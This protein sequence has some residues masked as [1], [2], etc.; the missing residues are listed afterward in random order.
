M[1]TYTVLPQDDLNLEVT[2]TDPALAPELVDDSDLDVVIQESENP[3]VLNITP[4]AVSITSAVTSVNAEVGDVV[5]DTDDIS[6][7]TTNL[8]YTDARAYAAN[9]GGTGVTYNSST[10]EISI[11]QSVATTAD[12][13]F[14]TV[15][16]TDEF[17]G[18]LDGSIRFTGRNTSGSTIEPGQVIY[19]SGLSGNTPTVDFAQ[20]NSSSTMPAFGIA[21]EQILNN[22][23]GQIATFGSQRNLDVAD[24]GETGITF[25]E[26]DILYVSAT[27]GGHLT[28]VPPSGEANQIQ[29]IGMLERASPT[30][31]TTIKVGGAG[32]SNDTPNLDTGNIFIGDSNNQAITSTLDTSIVP[33]NT[34]L[35]YTD[36]RA[37]TNFDSN[38]LA[39][40]TDDLT[41]GANNL[42]YTT[43][44]ANTDF[45]TRLATKD[46]GDL[47][48]GTNLYYTDAR[49]Q[50]VI[51]TNSAGFITASSTDTLTNK[52]GNISQWTNDAGYLTSETDS[53]TLS[54]SSPD[55]TISNG[56][57]VD[58][59][60][61][62]N[63][64]SVNTQTG[65]VVLDTD[66]VS[67]GSVNLY[68]TTTRANTD[69]D[70]RLATKSTSDLSEGA[71]LYYTDTRANSAI[72]ARVTGTFV[73]GLDYD[74]DGGTY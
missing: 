40:D 10:G 24:W 22:T 70:T 73:E 20:A 7:G 12:V 37:T 35:Y 39:A 2:V 50:S 60:A 57:V 72:D 3:V 34:N 49:V 36:A 43:A 9:S 62:N 65:V 55:L 23:P 58:I 64:T 28:N 51:D 53:Q 67:E 44:R 71:N 52:S 6:E 63:I 21:I 32:R 48:E 17:I 66:D 47:T 8:Y 14:N 27:E 42:Y 25:T 15:T 59:S 31:N 45:D 30:T 56:N 54:F 16:A 26:G 13:T 18:H 68:Y 1:T 19:I 38:F 33:E 69:F 5:L 46:T 74:S 61:I 4:A 41:E 29:N 11:G